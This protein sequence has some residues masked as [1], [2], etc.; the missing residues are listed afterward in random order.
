[1]RPL[2]ALLAFLTL[3]GTAWALNLTSANLT[4]EYVRSS[5]M[6]S[7][8]DDVVAQTVQMAGGERQAG[9]YDLKESSLK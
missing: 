1:M 3:N 4:H 2:I 7:G 9:H 8:A 6:S 5:D